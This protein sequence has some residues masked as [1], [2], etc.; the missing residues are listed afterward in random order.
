MSEAF[1]SVCVT[2][3]SC[4]VLSRSVVWT[5]CRQ[6]LYHLRQQGLQSYI[7]SLMPVLS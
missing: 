1:L 2:V 3:L 7:Q 6:I 5:L 4:A